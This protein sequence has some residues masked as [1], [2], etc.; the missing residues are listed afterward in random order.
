MAFRFPLS[1]ENC[2]PLR[3]TRLQLL[4]L[5]H[6]H[7]TSL[8]IKFFCMEGSDWRDNKKNPSSLRYNWMPTPRD[9]N[10]SKLRIPSNCGTSCL[11]QTVL[12]CLL[13]MWKPTQSTCL[14]KISY[15]AIRNGQRAVVHRGTEISGC[16]IAKTSTTVTPTSKRAGIVWKEGSVRENTGGTHWGE[17]STRNRNY[18][19]ISRKWD[20]KWVI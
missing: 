19:E 8:E 18:H 12:G 10:T 3:L 15:N 6:I 13:F 9:W 7:T 14:W 1:L 4:F 11:R 2:I 17:N 16:L 20:A 5:M